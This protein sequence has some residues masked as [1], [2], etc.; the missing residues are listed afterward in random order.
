MLNKSLH[1][2]F[3]SHGARKECGVLHNVHIWFGIILKNQI[4]LAN[5]G[6][7]GFLQLTVARR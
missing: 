7:S 4:I 5:H 3:P 1:F 2:F 6:I